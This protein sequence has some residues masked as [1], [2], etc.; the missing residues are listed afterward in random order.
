MQRE[1]GLQQTVAS[2]PHLLMLLGLFAGAA[3]F[4]G[5]N[6]HQVIARDLGVAIPA[7]SPIDA[8]GDMRVSPQEFA[9]Y[10]ATR[11]HDIDSNRDGSITPIEI[12]SYREQ[13]RRL[14]IEALLRAFD[15]NGDGVVSVR[16]LSAANMVGRAR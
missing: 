16:E 9:A 6:L 13:E 12:E 8:N 2:T 15:A 7:P 11:A 1:Y 5:W 3:L 14:Q 10:Y 4:S